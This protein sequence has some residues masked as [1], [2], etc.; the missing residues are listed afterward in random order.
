MAVEE[1]GRLQYADRILRQSGVTRATQPVKMDTATAIGYYMGAAQQQD[2][3]TST[4]LSYFRADLDQARAD[5][6][7]NYA[8]AIAELRPQQEASRTALNEMMRFVGIDPA[9]A[10]SGLQDALKGLT[11]VNTSEAARTLSLAQQEQDPAK[12]AE[13][14][15]QAISQLQGL[16]GQVNQATQQRINEQIGQITKPQMVDVAPDP[17][18]ALGRDRF[19]GGWNKYYA[20]REDYQNKQQQAADIYNS[21]MEKY[22]QQVAQIT[23]QAKEQQQADLASL[24]DITSKF[25]TSYKPEYDAAYT[26]AQVEQKL[27]ATPGYDFQER[28]GTQAIERASAARGMLG[29]ANT[30]LALQKY[31]QD[32]AS[33][34]YNT[35]LQNL[36]AIASQGSG[37]AGQI[38]GLFAEQGGLLSQIQSQKAE[39][40]QNAYNLIGKAYADAYTRSGDLEGAASNLYA[41]QKFQGQESA[42]SRAGSLAQ[43]IFQNEPK[44]RAADMQAGMNTG[45]LA[46]A[47]EEKAKAERGTSSAD[48]MG[49]GPTI[50]TDSMLD[51]MANNPGYTAVDNSGSDS[52][53]SV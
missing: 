13:L 8:K 21:Q 37:A 22:N 16:E 24:G 25:E 14:R 36:S 4:G 32:L 49:T 10:T 35:H 40:T 20:A 51:Q 18:L 52:G 31:G 38:A 7:S 45:L 12:R 23:Q 27:R 48:A 2:F 33:Q 19:P 5:I 1:I 46:A 26:G 44:M 6:Q 3:Y 42:K 30:V 43:T 15:E 34:Y 53:P 50:L 41:T 9:P 17:N 39:G 29:S 11:G 28:A 47:Q